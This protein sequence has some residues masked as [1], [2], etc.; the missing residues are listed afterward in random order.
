MSPEELLSSTAPQFGRVA[1]LGLG[2]IGGSVALAL[3]ARGLATSIVGY[4]AAPEAAEAAL[5][6]RAIT[7]FART[8]AE[9][10]RNANVIVLATPPRSLAAL[11]EEIRREV[12]PDALITD[13]ASTKRE[14][15]DVAERVLPQPQRFVGGHP[16]AGSEQTGIAAASADLFRAAEWCLTPT[17]RTDSQAVEQAASLVRALGAIPRVLPPHEHDKLV[18]L[19]SHLPL[20]VAAALVRAT[21]GFPTW[22]AA[23]ALAASGYR[24]TTRIAAGSP[25]MGRDILLGNA[26]EVVAALD[27]FLSAVADLRASIVAGDAVAIA[28]YLGAAQAARLA[29]Q[30]TQQQT[31]Q[32]ALQ[33]TQQ[34]AQQRGENRENT[35]NG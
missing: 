5:A 13:V 24:D 4:D 19:A 2:L 17:E 29:W 32:Q 28:D 34:G 11:L 26:E 7:T 27:A 3:A 6:R 20:A 23:S 22:D 31:Q 18:A 15:V 25:Q 30:Q 12:L 14:I 1:V 33:Q 10:V 21:T 16:M 9:A 8:P 35:Q